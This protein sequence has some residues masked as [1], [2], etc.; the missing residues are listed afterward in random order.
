MKETIFKALAAIICVVIFCSSVSTAVTELADAQATVAEYEAEIAQYGSNGGASGSNGGSSA[1]DAMFGDDTSSDMGSSDGTATTPDGTTPDGTTPDGGATN[2]G[3]PNGGAQQPAQLT[4]ADVIKLINE[5]TTAAA[6]GSYK[7]TRGGKFVKNID[8][9]G[10]TGALN[11]IIQGVDKNADLNSVVGGF[12]GIKKDPITGTVANGK[13]EGF[14]AKYMLKGMALTEAD[15]TAF[16]VSGNKYAVQIANCKTPDAS[17]PIAHATNDY[18]TFAEV[19]KG[20]SDSVGSAVKVVPEDSTANYKDIIFIA[21]IV[22]GKLT[23]LEYSYTLDA[24]LAIKLIAMTANGTGEADITG[25]Y[26]NIKY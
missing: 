4:K 1:L 26:T 23:E 10:A 2:D 5:T 16:K 3:A 20:I 7:L 11:K 15:V 6:K 18:I 17:S 25:K 12:L 19:N 22:D 14:D 24:K 13:G 8:V 21:T 9:G